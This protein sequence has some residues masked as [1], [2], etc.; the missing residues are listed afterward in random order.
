[1][2]LP[3]PCSLFVAEKRDFRDRCREPSTSP[4]A[5]RSMGKA[6]VLATTPDRYR[7]R[8]GRSG[9]LARLIF[10]CPGVYGGRYTYRQY[11]ADQDRQEDK[12]ERRKRKHLKNRLC[13]VL[14][15]AGIVATPTGLAWGRR[16]SLT[17]CK[18]RLILPYHYK[19]SHFASMR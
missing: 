3:S 7:R 19:C 5:R 9:H 14:F 15:M 11:R 12:D 4:A 8:Q 6:C 16:P 2:H 13:R 17:A 18:A 10:L 1:M